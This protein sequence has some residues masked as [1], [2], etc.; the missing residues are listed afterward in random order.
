M[1]SIIFLVL[2]HML[3]QLINS[4]ASWIVAN[5]G[6]LAS[7]FISAIKEDWLQLVK[8][9]LVPSPFAPRILSLLNL[10]AIVLMEDTFCVLYTLVCH[11]NKVYLSFH[12]HD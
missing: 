5:Q 6:L 9:H 2:S 8:M 12:K 3:M 7:S 4:A 10:L 1:S 11:T